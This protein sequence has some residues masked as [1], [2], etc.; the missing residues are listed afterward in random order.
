LTHAAW[1][2]ALLDTHGQARHHGQAGSHACI[3][4]CIC[5]CIVYMHMRRPSHAQHVHAH[6][7]G[8]LSARRCE[9]RQRQAAVTRAAAQP[10]A[11]IRLVYS[12]THAPASDSDSD[13]VYACDASCTHG[14]CT[15]KRVAAW[16]R[17]AAV[18]ARCRRLACEQ[19]GH[20]S[21]VVTHA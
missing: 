3:C 18:C 6:A 14:A 4:V 5:I 13:Y 9:L 17:G 7:G 1:P 21:C 16:R 10:V 11:R 15:L 8:S 2:G 20:G 12:V 19:R